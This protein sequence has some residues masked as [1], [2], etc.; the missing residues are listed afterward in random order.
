VLVLEP[1]S[2]LVTTQGRGR[3][4]GIEGI[5]VGFLPPLLDKRLYDAAWAI[6]E[7]EARAICRRLAKEE[8]VLVGT[9]TG[10]NVVAAIVLA[11]KLGPGKT[12]VTVACD[13]GLK[14]MRGTLFEEV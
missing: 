10:L 2:A 11:K 13:T 5:G 12:V 4:H 14:Y 3:T 1:E 6:S 8:G 9:S 7:D